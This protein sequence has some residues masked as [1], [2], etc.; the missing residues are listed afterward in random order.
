MLPATNSTPR[1]PRFT[2][3]LLIRHIP[4]DAAPHSSSA[5]WQPVSHR[6]QPGVPYLESYGFPMKIASAAAVTQFNNLIKH[7]NDFLGLMTISSMKE[8]AKQ[9]K[10]K[11]LN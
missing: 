5:R 6:G 9:S 4:H 7:F 1:K 2:D 10:I 3:N 11:N 8:E